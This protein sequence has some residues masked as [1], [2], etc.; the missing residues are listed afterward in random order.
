MKIR[1]SKWALWS[2][3]QQNTSCRIYRTHGLNPQHRELKGFHFYFY[4]EL[5]K[6]GKV[7]QVAE[8]TYSYLMFQLIQYGPDEQLVLKKFHDLRSISIGLF[9]GTNFKLI[10]ELYKGGITILKTD[11][12]SR[13]DEDLLCY[14]QISSVS[15]TGLQ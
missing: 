3:V 11:Q 8:L 10:I 1:Y 14:Q 5:S 6:L 7:D 13:L 4:I 2:V 9:E 12:K 15:D